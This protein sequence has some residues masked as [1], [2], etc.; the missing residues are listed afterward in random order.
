MYVDGSLVRTELGSPV[1]PG[2][3]KTSNQTISQTLTLATILL[4]RVS[5]VTAV[6]IVIAKP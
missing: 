4:K 3:S 5:I 1:A 2:S 6:A